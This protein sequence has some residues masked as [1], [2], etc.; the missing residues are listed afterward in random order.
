[1]KISIKFLGVI[2]LVAVIGLSFISCG[3]DDGDNN[4]ETSAQQPTITVQPQSKVYFPGTTA[5]PLTVTASVSDGGSLSYQWYSNT[6]SY[7]SG[8]VI[9]GANTAS[10]TPSTADAG[11]VYYSVV[12]TNTNQGKTAERRSDW[13]EIVTGFKEAKKFL[14]AASSVAFGGGRF[15]VGRAYGQ[16]AWSSD[17]INWTE[18][19][20]SNVFG[21]ISSVGSIAYGGGRFIA[22][23]GY[24]MGWSTNGESWTLIN[25]S[26]AFNG[27]SDFVNYIAYGNNRFFVKGDGTKTAYSDDNGTTWT[28]AAANSNLHTGI[29]AGN[30]NFILYGGTGSGGSGAYVQSFSTYWQGGNITEITII[31]DMIYAN[32]NLIAVGG[33]KVYTKTGTGGIFSD[34]TEKS[35]T[36]IG[37]SYSIYRIGYGA[38]RL[39]VFAQQSTNDNKGAYSD[40]NGT[41]WTELPLERSYGQIAYGNGCFVATGGNSIYY[42]VYQ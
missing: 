35:P 41:N 13:T 21:N 40:N 19:D 15:V 7:A 37:G 27:T 11:T 33:N 4:N 29:V 3:G 8:T 25:A 36:S 31:R 9:E 18:V 2:A 1:M 23:G 38:G 39:I 28:A 24:K 16:T 42:T 12:I 32:N 14:S 20:A 10:Y 6:V 30:D 34:W 22:V 17:G 5:E 26:P